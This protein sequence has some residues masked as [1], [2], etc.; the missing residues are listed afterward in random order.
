MTVG[1]RA[2]ASGQ[3]GRRRGGY[4]DLV[5]TVGGGDDHS[6]P[7]A[8]HHHHH[9]ASN[10]PGSFSSALSRPFL[11]PFRSKWVASLPARRPSPSLRRSAPFIAFDGADSSAPTPHALRPRSILVCLFGLASLR[12]GRFHPVLALLPFGAPSP[13]PPPSQMQSVRLAG[14]VVLLGGSSVSVLS[15]LC[16]D[17]MAGVGTWAVPSPSSPLQDP[18]RPCR[19]LTTVEVLAASVCAMAA[20]ATAT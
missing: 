3:A 8:N 5:V 18:A 20:A 17:W 2:R 6:V 11:L 19:L 13:S 12:P 1:A 4:I 9:L 10:R 14:R 15:S 7:M 16:A